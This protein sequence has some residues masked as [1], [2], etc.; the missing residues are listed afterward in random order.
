MVEPLDG[1]DRRTH[2]RSLL[3][4]YLEELTSAGVQSPDF[5]EAWDLYRQTPV[6]GLATWLHTLSGGGFQPFDQC[7]ATI[8]RFAGAYA[9][10]Q[11]G[12]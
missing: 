5:A 1:G 10:H 2:E 3:S 9:D 11:T 8:D 6:F 12:R 4:D 7:L